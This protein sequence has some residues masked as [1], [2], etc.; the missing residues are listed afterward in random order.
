VQQLPAETTGL[1]AANGVQTP[2]LGVAFGI[3][4]DRA[5]VLSMADAVSPRAASRAA[6]VFLLTRT[7]RL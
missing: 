4:S 7:L 1:S 5:P 2:V 6:P 3:V